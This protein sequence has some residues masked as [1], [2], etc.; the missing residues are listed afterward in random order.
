ME[1]S[2]TLTLGDQEIELVGDFTPPESPSMD[3]D[4]NNC[5]EI[6]A[7]FSIESVYFDGVMIHEF[8]DA[9]NEITKGKDIW[10]V[11]EEKAIEQIEN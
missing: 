8:L 5:M 7:D 2:I 3:V 1:T 10:T 9:L 11:L 6:K 4:S